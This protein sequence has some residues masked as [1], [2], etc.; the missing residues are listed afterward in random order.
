MVVN[1]LVLRF[2][3]NIRTNQE[4]FRQVRVW[5]EVVGAATANPQ[6]SAIVYF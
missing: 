4:S 2:L 3:F 6:Q 1:F 5:V